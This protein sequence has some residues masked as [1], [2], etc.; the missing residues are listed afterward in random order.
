MMLTSQWQSGT[1]LK[2]GTIYIYFSHLR[3]GRE[4]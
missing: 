2:K 4:W 3:L 1:D